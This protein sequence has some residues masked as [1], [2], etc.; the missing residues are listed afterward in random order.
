MT[1]NVTKRDDK[2]TCTFRDCPR[3]PIQGWTTCPRHY[4]AGK[5]EGPKIT[6]A[7]AET[8]I[9]ALAKESVQAALDLDPGLAGEKLDAI[10]VL[11]RTHR[12]TKRRIDELITDEPDYIRAK[13]GH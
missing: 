13:Y 9:K 7:E 3:S 11:R 8:Q 1:V 12:I 10:E 5:Q 4:S 2:R 6:K